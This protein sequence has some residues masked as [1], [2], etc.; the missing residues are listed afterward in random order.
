MTST[1]ARIVRFIREFWDQRGY[2]PTLSEIGTGVG[3]KSRSSAAYQIDQLVKAGVV[4]RDPLRPRTIR[5]PRHANT[6]SDA[7]SENGGVS[8]TIKASG[9][10]PT[11][12]DQTPNL[13]NQIGARP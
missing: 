7:R 8:G 10:A 12:P 2:A 9:G 13:S 1:Q 11:P 5:L 4:E 3:M 6:T